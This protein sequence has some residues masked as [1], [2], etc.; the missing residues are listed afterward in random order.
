MKEQLR[1]VNIKLISYLEHQEMDQQ[2]H[3]AEQIKLHQLLA[4]REQV[5]S[6]KFAI[7]TKENQELREILQNLNMNLLQ[8]QEVAHQ[9][10]QQ[11]EEHKVK[12]QQ[13]HEKQEETNKQCENL[14]RANKDLNE[15]VQQLK[16]KLVL[17]EEQQKQQDHENVQEHNLNMEESLHNNSPGALRHG[18]DTPNH[19]GFHCRP[20]NITHCS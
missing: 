12:E 16:S 3:Q 15:E 10:Q 17:I 8:V 11:N 9:Q 2:Q 14:A 5:N 20:V 4:Q 19:E 7:I 18:V 13:F 1:D 6:E